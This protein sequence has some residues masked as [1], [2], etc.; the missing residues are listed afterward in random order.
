MPRRILP[1]I[2]FDQG[3]VC[4]AARLD[5]TLG[6]G[7]VGDDLHLDTVQLP[8][9]LRAVKRARPDLLVDALGIDANQ[10]RGLLRGKRIGQFFPQQKTTG[11]CAPSALADL[12]AKW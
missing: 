10:P 3:L 12:G 5:Q 7:S 1:E 2:P 8:A 6:S 4:F 11:K 9:D